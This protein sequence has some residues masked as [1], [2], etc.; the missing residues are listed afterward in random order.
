MEGVRVD[1]WV[2]TGSSVSPHYDSLIAKLMVFSPEGRPAAIELMQAALAE[3][4]VWYPLIA[5]ALS[6]TM[7]AE[8]LL[9]ALHAQHSIAAPCCF[10]KVFQ[11][12]VHLAV[13]LSR[14]RPA[15]SHKNK[16]KMLLLHS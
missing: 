12:Q 5:I 8:G 11:Y 13:L 15:L 1:T 6:V 14:V 2:E 16:A 4:K 10:H 9:E 3:T 7:S